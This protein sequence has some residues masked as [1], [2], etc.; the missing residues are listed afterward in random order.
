MHDANGA[1]HLAMHLREH[2]DTPAHLLTAVRA[3]M[4]LPHD[5]ADAIGGL[6]ADVPDG[7]AWLLASF[8]TAGRIDSPQRP[9][10]TIRRYRLAERWL[11]RERAGV[12]G[13][14]DVPRFD[15]PIPTLR[16]LDQTRP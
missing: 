3:T 2:A 16:L 5:L 12:N 14:V 1:I 8:Y 15:G 13:R 7:P 11:A 4:V 9:D 6:A 10:L